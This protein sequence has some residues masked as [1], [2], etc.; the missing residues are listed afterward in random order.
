MIRLLVASLTLALVA[1]GGSIAVEDL[2]DE[3]KDARCDYLVKCD[4]IADRAT[5]DAAI[6]VA[7]AELATIQAGIDNGTI[8]YDEDKAADCIDQ[9]GGRSCAFEGFHDENS[10]EGVFTGTVAT[11]GA[12]VIDAQCAN[13]GE[14]V[15][16][17]GNCDPDT[18]CCPGTCMG[19]A[20][21]S[22]LGGPCDDE[23]HVCSNAAYCKPGMGSGAIGTCTALIAGEGSAC[24]DLRACANPLYCNVDFQA[25]TGTCKKP[26]ASNAACVRD[27]LIACAD[28]RDY[29]NATSLTCV[30]RVA[31]GGACT[32][33]SMPCVDFA[34]C[35]NGSCVAEIAAGGACVVDGDVDCTGDLECTAGT[36]QP[37]VEGPT[38][39]L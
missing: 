36:C 22:A 34:T 23:I 19:G 13:Q 10:C 1:C 8:K 38:C 39:T 31:V 29:C 16:S 20:S 17:A 5:C 27:D 9:L 21:E 26:A 18:A 33:G 11:G 24:D 15:P 32:S 37:P 2:P 14:C 6:S 28:R 4:G 35:V 7:D 25:G 3:V 30:R 12:C